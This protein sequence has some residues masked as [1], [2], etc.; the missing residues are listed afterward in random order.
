MKKQSAVNLRHYLTA[1]IC[2]TGAVLLD[3]ATKYLAVLHL[4]SQEAFVLLPGIFELQYLENRGAAFGLFQNRQWFF[5]AGAVLVFLFIAFFYARIP[6][7]A[8]YYPMRV[9]AVLVCAGAIGNM[10][11]RIRFQYV[12][13]FFY[14]RL[15]DFPVFN[16]A[17]CYVV[18]ACILF[19]YVI[20]FFYK[21][22]EL[23]WVFPEKGKK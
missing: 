3:Q 15:I 16:V 23:E 18:V 4:K 21:D 2:C 14:F 10:I 5:V 17:D 7:G 20:L 6:Q 9:S 19:G 12:V 13:D 22:E 1:L 8:R 11:D